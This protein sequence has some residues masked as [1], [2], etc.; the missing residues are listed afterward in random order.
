MG[1][2][3]TLFARMYNYCVHNLMWVFEINKLAKLK[4]CK[5][6]KIL[7]KLKLGGSQICCHLP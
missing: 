7:K 3:E 1:K 2:T 5:S 4:K 6:N